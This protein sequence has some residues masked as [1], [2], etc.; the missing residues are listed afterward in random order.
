M[1][2]I[3][4]EGI[5]A[6]GKETLSKLLTAFLQKK[7]LNVV[8]GSFPRYQTPIGKV[9]KSHLQGEFTLSDEAFHTLLEA[10]RIDFMNTITEM[11]QIGTDVMVLDRFTLSNLAFGKAK[12][13]DVI[14]LQQLQQKVIQPH[15]T[16]FIDVSVETSFD[17]RGVGRD[18][19]E[20]D[21]TLLQ[22]ARNAYNELV[23]VGKVFR[24]DGE[25]SVNEIFE[26]VLGI[27]DKYL[28]KIF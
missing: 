24:I 10:D 14:W 2:L 21:F 12:G 22:G 7:G 16:F 17:R 8:H 23:E 15:L 9:I 11:K 5:D 20:N 6:S 28:P 13:L 4:F 25:S 18:R 3:A 19:Y 27:V 1:L 26:A